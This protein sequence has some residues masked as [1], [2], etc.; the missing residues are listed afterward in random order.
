LVWGS[1]LA[2]AWALEA[3][4]PH[5]HPVAALVCG[6]AAAFLVAGVLT[7]VSR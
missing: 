7:S 4:P 5:L 3:G 2:A 6:L 1:G